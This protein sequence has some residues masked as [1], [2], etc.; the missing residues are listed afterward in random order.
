MEDKM[1]LVAIPSDQVFCFQLRCFLPAIR[2]ANLVAIPSDQV[3]CFQQY[4][5]LCTRIEKETSQSLL[6]RS[7]VSNREH[8]DGK[9]ESRVCR[10]PF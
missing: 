3:F 5:A 8:E 10:N 7:S 9:R 1:L 2:A 4:Q 6:I